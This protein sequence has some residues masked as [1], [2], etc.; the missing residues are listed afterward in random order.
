L[1]RV[2]FR[3]NKFNINP[4]KLRMNKQNCCAWVLSVATVVG[5][6]SC[7]EDIG[8]GT[9]EGGAAGRIAPQIEL[10]KDVISSAKIASRSGEEGLTVSDL[11]IMLTRQSSSSQNTTV[12]SPSTVTYSYSYADFP[13]DKAFPVGNYL[14]E[15]AYGDAEAEGYDCGPSYYGS[16][17]ISVLENETTPVSITATLAQSMV[18][19]VYTDEFK[20][21]MTAWSAE[22]NSEKSL[23]PFAE[24]EQSDASATPLP[25]YVVPGDE[26]V[27]VSFTKANG[28][29]AKIKAAEFTGEARHHY[30][31]TVGLENG[32]GDAVLTVKYDDALAQEEVEIDLSEELMSAP[33]P[34]ITG[35]GVANG[36]VFTVNEGTE[37]NQ[38]IKTNI[39]ARGTLGEVVLTT[40]SED[41]LAK[42][43]PSKIDLL[44]ATAAQQATLQQLG[45]STL[46]LWKNP[47]V[48]GVI[49]FTGVLANTEKAVFTLLVTDKYGKTSEEFQF[50]YT[51]VESQVVIESVDE[52]YAGDTSLSLYVSYTGNKNDINVN[53]LGGRWGAT[54]AQSATIKSIESTSTDNLYKVT[55]GIDALDNTL[56]LYA[57]AGKKVSEHVTVARSEAL[58]DVTYKEDDIWATKATVSG[59]IVES[60]KVSSA[61]KL[62]YRKQGETAWNTLNTTVS[63]TALSADISG[64]TAGTTYEF[65]AID[66][67]KKVSA[68]ETFTTEAATQLPNADMESWYRVA[69][70]TDYWWIDYPGTDTNAVWGTMNLLTT[71]GGGS[72]ANAF[73]RS[74]CAYNASSG[75]RQSTDKRSGTY[76]ALVK[77][78]GWGTNNSAAVISGFGTCKNVTPGELYLGKYDADSK[79]AVYSGYAFTS[80]PTSFTF[81][82]KYV[83]VGNTSNDDYAY[84]QVEVYDA[85]GNVIASADDTMKTVVSDYTE[86]TL[87][88]TY[89]AGAAKAAKIMVRFKSS[90][91]N[92][93]ANSTYMT[94][95]PGSN[96]STGEYSGSQLYVDDLTLNY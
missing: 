26:T 15:A 34:T 86:K 31:L 17:Q 24:T 2:C 47:D 69:G 60:G 96:L 13:S 59:T 89:T 33:A 5:V 71:S 91:D 1:R 49:D 93:A 20:K 4:K 87:D 53:Y 14:V 16:Q 41:L 88:L 11:T 92:V 7:H 74:G 21:Y 73:D 48:M 76:A 40:D 51:F 30:T 82:Y 95:P 32:A 57:T 63:G 65:A 68:L 61:V 75:T 28:Q 36:S 27:Y 81:Y 42:G 64:L 35:V 3:K 66:G 85:S 39:T 67:I 8:F 80:R 43:W 25:V 38:T 78:V 10:D 55:I 90:H 22:I 79:K 84:V 46:G 56:E 94:P 19:L 45:L 54:T 62:A 77:T 37:F 12:N 18:T 50:S 70:K 83:K 72:S 44:S 23:Q 52:F 58:V 29:S 6:T 9:E